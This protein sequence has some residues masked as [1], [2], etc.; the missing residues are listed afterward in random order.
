MTEP[1]GVWLYG[2]AEGVPAAE[3]SQLTG[4]GGG[5]VRAVTAAGL[6]AIASNVRLDEFGESALRANLEDI[7]WLEATA[8]AHHAVIDAVSHD[9]PVVPMRLATV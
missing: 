1:A 6:A 7:A 2:V 8:T 3:L 9:Q 4:V 5:P